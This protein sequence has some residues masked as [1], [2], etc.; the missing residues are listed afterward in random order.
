V[1]TNKVME[2][3]FSYNLILL[4]A[5][6]FIVPITVY[7]TSGACSYHLGVNCNAGADY[8]GSAICNDGWRDSL[9]SFSNTDECKKSNAC[10]ISQASNLAYFVVIAYVDTGKIDT[11]LLISTKELLN[12]EIVKTKN[13]LNSLNQSIIEVQ[14]NNDRLKLLGIYSP[15]LECYS[16]RIEEAKSYLSALDKISEAIKNEADEVSQPISAIQSKKV[17]SAT[18]IKSKVEEMKNTASTTVPSS[19]PVIVATSSPVIATSSL[20]IQT[21]KDTL[22]NGSSTIPQ[23]KNNQS[24]FNKINNFFQK[25]TNFFKKFKF[26]K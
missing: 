17:V 20:E 14:D 21:E 7:A 19:S 23:Q 11:S 26:W 5:F 8:D 12:S 3:I 16:L 13:S 4:A 25:I 6:L 15:T 10:P 24:F 22:I 18:N 9:V 2:K 1:E